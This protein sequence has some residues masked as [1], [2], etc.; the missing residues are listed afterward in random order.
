MIIRLLVK[1]STQF[2]YPRGLGILRRLC[3]SGLAGFDI[4]Q[5]L[6]RSARVKRL[7]RSKGSV[8]QASALTYCVQLSKQLLH[9]KPALT[10]PAYPIAL[11]LCLTAAL[12]AQTTTGTW[13]VDD[14][15][16][17]SRTM[18][19]PADTSGAIADQSANPLQSRVVEIATGMNYWDGQQWSPSDPSFVAQNNGF[20]A[21]RTQHRVFIQS[22]LNSVGAV[23][24]IT[25]DGITLNSTLVGIGLYDAAS[26]QSTIIGSIT[27]CAGVLVSS[28]ELVFENA[29]SGVCGDIHY[30]MNAGSFEQDVVLT[31]RLRPSDFGY[32]D[33]TS[34]IQILTEFYNAPEPDEVEFPLF[35]EQDQTVRS[36]MASPDLV[37]Y[38]LGFGEFVMG[39][40]KAY[41]AA[42]AANPQ[43]VGSTVAKQFTTILGRTFLVE[44]VPYSCIA[45]GLESLPECDPEVASAKQ[46]RKGKAT[47]GYASIPQ[48]QTA[49]H[50]QSASTNPIRPARL[51][52][53]HSGV[54]IDYIASIG[55]TISTAYVFQADTT[56]LVSSTV[57]CNGAATIEGGVVFKHKVNTTINLNSTLTCKT[58]IYR[59]AFFTCVDDDSVGDT[60]NG[61]SGSGYTGTISGSGYANPALST[62][63]TSMTL[64]NLRFRYAK[65]AIALSGPN[66]SA[67]TVNHSQFLSCILGIEVTG[68]G[69]GTAGSTGTHLT[70]N[71]ALMTKVTT[72]FTVSAQSWSISTA[73]AQCT[74]DQGTT[75]FAVTTG[76]GASAAASSTN[77]IL[78]NITTI[79]T[80]NLT[81][82]GNKNGLY[83]CPSFGSGTLTNTSSPFQ[84]VGAGAHYLS[85]AAFRNAGTT[86]SLP[87]S[88]LSDLQARTTQPPEV[89]AD[90]L[91]NTNLNLTPWAARDTSSTPDLG[92][93]YDSLDYAF[94]FT[95]LTNAAISLSGG[96]VIATFDT[97]GGTYGLA[98]GGGSQFVS[99]GTPVIKNWIVRYNM[100][101]EQATTN[102]SALPAAFSVVT[103]NAPAPSIN[104]YFTDF[105][106]AAQDADHF[107]AYTNTANPTAF[108]FWACQFHGG[109]INSTYPTINFTNS[110]FERVT[111]IL[112]NQDT[113]TPY[114][115]SPTPIT[116]STA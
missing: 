83:A 101:Q 112:T 94:G 50:N 81:R 15:G 38:T 12:N 96:G 49:A 80:G 11:L 17:N 72:P 90:V 64:N 116:R 46:I 14:V 36:R 67:Y 53:L 31:G 62:S 42:T 44:S 26:G 73:L 92:Y 105:S 97:N 113:N 37:D 68:T 13:L 24:V 77:S 23:T 30:I 55:G 104:C 21:Q 29:F 54:V 93:H 45:A 8:V 10:K 18:V 58:S 78:A 34:R 40:G 102:W 66:G 57:T 1:T 87:A 47:I 85:A 56:Y 111:L 103:T 5:S 48:A 61:Y 89:Y 65:A 20:A 39:L 84:T 2:Y 6:V 63:Q 22:D 33:A 3:E 60:L 71:N 91:L 107:Y 74:I 4:T 7:A 32:P 88:L 43:A 69:C 76:T 59:P 100:A 52:A 25:R 114:I 109:K 98:L 99:T 108:T 41:V 19:L 16:P 110:L 106:V 75:L 9:W 28:N 95:Y 79:N 115:L 35:V 70:V 27:N 86:N 82:T 51:T